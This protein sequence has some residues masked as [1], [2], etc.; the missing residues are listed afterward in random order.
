MNPIEK[1]GRFQIR[2]LH[3]LEK[4]IDHINIIIQS[5]GNDVNPTDIS[6]RPNVLA[7]LNEI[8]LEF[9]N[10]HSNLM[11]QIVKAG[12]GGSKRSGSKRSG[13]KRSGSKRSGSK[14]SGSKRKHNR[15][16]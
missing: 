11:A 6:N 10:N 15:K 2:Q 16:N 14:R 1:L 4:N 5:L 7:K 9:E 8:K 12:R 13:S 3:D